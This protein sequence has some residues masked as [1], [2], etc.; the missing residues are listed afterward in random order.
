MKTA[1]SS[2]TWR[3]R[4]GLLP[5]LPRHV[6]S[7]PSSTTSSC[8]TPIAG[9][10]HPVGRPIPGRVRSSS[11]VWWLVS[12]D[13]GTTGATPIAVRLFDRPV[14]STRDEIEGEAGRLA[15]FLAPEGVDPD[16]RI[17]DP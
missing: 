16:L 14:R 17:E 13:T 15:R 10:W 12:G 3:T 6:D 5:I 1:A 7:C 9:G 4:P 11:T 2:S 8:R